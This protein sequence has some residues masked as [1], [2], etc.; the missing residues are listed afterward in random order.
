ML[1]RKF[2]A[3]KRHTFIKILFYSFIGFFSCMMIFSYLSQKIVNSIAPDE[4]VKLLLAEGFN[5]QIDNYTFTNPLDLTKPLTLIE[6]GLNFQYNHILKSDDSTIEAIN[7]TNDKSEDPTVYIYNTHDEEAYKVSD[8]QPYNITPNVKLASYILQEKLDDLGLKAI[9]E[10]SSVGDILTTYDWKYANSYSASRILLEKAKQKYPSLKY[11][12]D[13]HRDSS[14][15]DKTTINIDN[16][17]YAKVLFIVGLENTNYEPN[18]KMAND[19]SNSLNTSINNISRG[20]YK[21]EG[22]GVNGVYNQD[23]SPNSMLIEIGGYENS[24][25]SVAKTINIL[26]ANLYKYIEGDANEKAKL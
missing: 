23:F 7:K 24:I 21:K 8:S 9:V 16:T 10:T 25:D 14:N 1:M 6:N 15:G 22:P 17:D 3:K 19:L 13:I 2:K 12:I 4:Y 26:G 18:L 20:I 11:Y 5:N